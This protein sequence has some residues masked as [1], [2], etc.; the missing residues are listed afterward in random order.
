MSS[1]TPKIAIIGA[2]PTSLTLSSLLSTSSIPY[3]TYEATPSP[4]HSGGSLDIHTATGQAAL[5]AAGLLPE[6]RKRA[7]PESDCD[8]IVVLG[9]GEVVWDENGDESVKAAEE[10]VKVGEDGTIEGRP[11]IDRRDLMEILRSGVEDERIVFGKKLLKM[12]EGSGGE[13]YD[14]HFADGSVERGFDVVIG[15]DGAWSR[16][17]PLL[18]DVKPRYSGI[19]AAELWVDDV[20][21]K[22][23][24]WLREYVG[25]GSCFA[26][27]EGRAVIS[28][29]QSEGGLRTYAAIRVPEDFIETCGIDWND[30]ETARHQLVDKYFSDIGEDLKRVLYASGDELIPRALF[31]LPV[32]FKWEHRKGVTLLGD[33]AHLMTPFAGIGVNVGMT[34]AL[35]LWQELVKASRGEKSYDEA[36]RSYE[37]ELFPRARKAMEKT[38]R[39]KKNHFSEHGSKERADM[40]KQLKGQSN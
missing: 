9:T 3:T 34:D 30:K 6:F 17:R 15:G 4:R 14:L 31:E 13:K 25:V 23:K 22:E 33:A 18:S 20:E 8:K 11:E 5:K 2:G 7:R 29:R 12:E 26:F 38:A 10:G 32:D 35:V 39:G 1:T 27:G 16:V 40:M 21:T 36:L 28:Q 24:E 19:S 37:E